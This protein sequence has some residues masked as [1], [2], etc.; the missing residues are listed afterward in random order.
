MIK[1]IFYNYYL[2]SAL[3]FLVVLLVYSY[4]NTI[5][6]GS[7]GLFRME[8]P[9]TL[10]V[11]ILSL[12][13]L[14]PSSYR[15]FLAMVPVGL[16]YMVYDLYYMIYNTLF[17]FIQI[18]KFGELVEVINWKY[19]VILAL[20]GLVAL[21]FLVN[22]RW[23]KKASVVSMPLIILVTLLL[24]APQTVQNSFR[25]LTKEFVG[26][27][28]VKNTRKNGRLVMAIYSEAE[29]RF[30]QKNLDKYRSKQ[31]FTMSLDKAFNLSVKPRNVHLI[32]LES[33][34]DP[35]LL[36]KIKPDHNSKSTEY[37]AM[38]GGKENLSYSPVFGG[39]TSQAEFEVLCGVPAFNRVSSAEFNAFNGSE[40]YCLPT[41]LRTLG[42]KSY[43]SNAYKP[44][45]FNTVKAYKSIGFDEQYF[46][47]AYTNNPTYIKQIGELKDMFD[48]D[49]FDQN[50]AFIKSKIA[51]KKPI[52]NYVLGIYGHDPYEIHKKHKMSINTRTENATL[53]R[54]FSQ[55]RLRTDALTRYIKQLII[56]DPSSVIIVL[57]DHLPPLDKKNIYNKYG[58]AYDLSVN[59]SLIVDRGEVV[60]LDQ[61]TT[62]Y[63]LYRYILN[64]LSEGYYCQNNK[65]DVPFQKREDLLDDYYSIISFGSR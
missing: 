44:S 17:N 49:L 64:S 32:V 48:G 3:L 39:N 46:P 19:S 51:S 52:F 18:N 33:Y 55:Y 11:F 37:L 54:V 58:Y 4:T 47:D 45:F 25:M 53:D 65:C 7:S 22:I 40:S 27:S 57:S 35:T 43:A 14:K 2:K 13:W 42:Y 61:K 28:I 31:L 38:F 9:L 26:F 34:I 12:I 6:R 41:I 63:N 56:L 1:K 24:Y 10:Y 29:R 16:F 36:Q 20:M 15:I 21:L 23:S 30:I 50:I 59:R 5:F 62:H 8:I 60:K